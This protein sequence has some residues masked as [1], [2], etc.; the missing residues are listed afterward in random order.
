MSGARTI[1][2]IIILYEIRKL[3]KI[4]VR[5][6]MKVGFINKIHKFGAKIVINL[7]KVKNLVLHQREKVFYLSPWKF[8]FKLFNTVVIFCNIPSRWKT[9]GYGQIVKYIE[10]LSKELC[11]LR[12]RPHRHT[13]ILRALCWRFLSAW[14]CMLVIQGLSKNK[15]EKRELGQLCNE[16]RS[17]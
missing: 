3:I 6:N 13:H 11:N 7:S 8:M 16:S 17:R 1:S 15:K 12:S 5:E 4:N 10:S 9:P 14:C 2:H